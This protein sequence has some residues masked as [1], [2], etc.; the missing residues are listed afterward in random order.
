MSIGPTNVYAPQAP[1]RESGEEALLRWA[2]WL[3]RRPKIALAAGLALAAVACLSL[4]LS[5]CNDAKREQQ[6]KETAAA[7]AR[8]PAAPIDRI[9][10]PDDD[11]VATI[12]T[13]RDVYPLACECDT[14]PLAI[15]EEDT[16]GYEEILKCAKR[17]S[18]RCSAA[19][20]RLTR[21][22]TSA[23]TPCSRQIADG[24]TR[25]ILASAAFLEASVAWLE[26]NKAA[27][28]GPL[29]GKGMTDGCNDAKPG[30]CPNDEPNT[31]PENSDGTPGKYTDATYYP[32]NSVE[33]TKALLQCGR[34]KGNV[35]AIQKV[36]YRL[37]LSCDSDSRP[38]T[39]DA[40]LLFV[41]ASGRRLN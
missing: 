27:L 35:C 6:R 39:P 32:I 12:A 20:E 9:V 28:V 25:T 4:G 22:T 13:L 29:T 2:N 21:L 38:S 18:A 33:C 14:F 30:T 40:S 8:T 16:K 26:K 37:G 24:A 3:G 11:A 23:T 5:W 31:W 34:D 41:R 19:K 17:L 10:T 36:T 7:A 1:R 15:C